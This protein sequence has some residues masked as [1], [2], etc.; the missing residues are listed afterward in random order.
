MMLIVENALLPVLLVIAA[1]SV[2]A[3][4]GIITAEQWRGVEKI[5]YFV[6]FPA[7]IIHTVSRTD[8][9]SLPAGGIAATL[10]SSILVTGSLALLLRPFLANRFK[11]SSPRF[12][13]IF[14]GA[15]RWNT[16]V[17][18]ALAD[19]MIGPEGVALLAVAIVT[20]I[21][22]L[23]IASVLVLARYAKG[24]PPGA[25]KILIDLVKNPF[26]WST[27]VGLMLNVTGLPLPVF[28]MSTLKIL[29][30]RPAHRHC[31]R[32][33]GARISAHCAGRALL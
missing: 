30:R 15:I 11:V 1:G 24:S 18:L 3:R 8:F 20:M 7:I 2:V 5:A 25:R 23:N 10:L 27:A 21:P 4:M 12:T 29:E 6:L 19:E 28:F 13:S 26:I 32:R 17:A 22:V 31:L 14:Q 16:F 33:R 9:S